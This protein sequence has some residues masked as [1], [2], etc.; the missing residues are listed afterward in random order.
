MHGDET[1]SNG[2]APVEIDI[3]TSP[4]PDRQTVT[5]DGERLNEAIDGVRVREAVTHEDDRGS[6]CEVYNPAWDFTDEPLVYVYTV[7]IRPGQRKGWVVHLEQD[8]RLFFSRGAAKAVLYDAR[9]TSPTHKLIQE[10][11]FGDFSRGL[12]RIPAGVFHAVVNIGSVDAEFVNMP[13]RPY[14]HENPDK[15][16]LA[17]DTDAIPYEF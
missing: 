15:L 1:K 13:T 9:P 2:R 4:S 5:P 11:V 10:V 7:T 17:T 14:R 12:L 16:R 6:L 8:D 3:A